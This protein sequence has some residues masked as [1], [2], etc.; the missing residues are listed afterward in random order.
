MSQDPTQPEVYAVQNRKNRPPDF[1]R[2]DHLVATHASVGHARLG[3]VD[4]ECR[5]LLKKSKWGTLDD[6]KG[7]IIYLDFAFNEPRDERLSSAVVQVTLDDENDYLK[8]QFPSDKTTSPLQIRIFGPH[9]IYGTPKHGNVGIKAGSIPSVGGIGYESIAEEYSWKLE[10]HLKPNSVKDTSGAYKVLQWHFTKNELQT[11][12]RHDSTIHTAFSFEHG[13]QPFYIRLDVRGKLER[14]SSNL[15]NKFSGIRKFPSTPSEAITL[16]NFKR[17]EIF[18]TPLDELEK[19]LELSMQLE[20]I[21]PPLAPLVVPE[22]EGQAAFE[23]QPQPMQQP[24]IIM[25]MEGLQSNPNSAGIQKNHP[26]PKP[27]ES[28]ETE[29]VV[30][31]RTPPQHEDIRTVSN[32]SYPSSVPFTNQL[33]SSGFSQSNPEPITEFTEYT[34]EDSAPAHQIQPTKQSEAFQ[35]FTTYSDSRFSHSHE[36]YIITLAEDLLEKIGSRDEQTLIRVSESLPDLLKSFALQMGYKAQTT[37]HQEI[38]V[39][40]HKNSKRIAESFRDQFTPE[41]SGPS[42]AERREQYNSRINRFLEDGADEAFASRAPS[43]IDLELRSYDEDPGQ[44]VDEDD[45]LV[46]GKEIEPPSVQEQEYRKLMTESP[47]YLWLIKT[48]QREAF[49]SR[50]DSNLMER[51]GATILK[52]LPSPHLSRK[53]SSKEHTAIFQLDWD[54]ISFLK[55][56]GYSQPPW[57]A[58]ERAITLT[59]SM[60][61]AQA[62]TTVDYISQVWSTSGKYAIALLTAAIRNTAG[63]SASLDLPNGGRLTTQIDGGKVVVTIIGVTPIII[64]VGQQLVWLSAALRSSSFETGVAICSPS[65]DVVE[66]DGRSNKG[67]TTADIICAVNFEITLA[68]TTSDEHQGHCW[69]KMFRNPVIVQGYPIPLKKHPGLGLE[70]PLA[71]MATLVGSNQ[72]SDFDGKTFIKGFSTML[73]AMKVAGDLIVWHYFYNSLQ[74]Y[75][76]YLYDGWDAAMGPSAQDIGLVELDTARHVVGWCSELKWNAGASDAAYDKID[77]SRLPRPHTGCF[78]EKVSISGGKFITVGATIAPGVKDIPI[79]VTLNSYVRKL[80]WLHSQYVIFWDEA[81]KRGW[82]VNGTSALLH[83]VRTSL[84]RSSTDDVFSSAL[85]FSPDKMVYPNDVNKPN[86]AAKVLLD[87]I[88][89][90]LEV[91][92]GKFVHSTEVTSQNVDGNV[93]EVK[94]SKKTMQATLFEDIV[95]DRFS[96]LERMIAYQQ[97]G[98]QNGINLKLRVRQHLEG[99]DFMD[100]ATGSI[101]HG[102]VATLDQVSYSWVEFAHSISAVFLFGKNF[103]EMIEPIRACPLWCTLPKGKYYLAASVIHLKMIQEREQVNTPSMASKFEWLTPS[104]PVAPCESCSHNGSLDGHNHNPVQILCPQASVS[105]TS[106]KEFSRPMELED[107][108]AVILGDRPKLGLPFKIQPRENL[109]ERHAGSTAVPKAAQD[110]SSSISSGSR[111]Q[112]SELSSFGRGSQGQGSE[113]EATSISAASSSLARSASVRSADKPSQNINEDKRKAS[114]AD[115]STDH[116]TPRQTAHPLSTQDPAPLRVPDRGMKTSLKRFM[117]TLR[118]VGGNYSIK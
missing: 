32:D 36:N 102:C 114:E 89:R 33:Y 26:S 23:D 103:G 8:Q 34:R 38:S 37:V 22:I 27:F 77:R 54:P 115:D 50:G 117:E 118:N 45:A 78:L 83:L 28:Y 57:E 55:E 5:L 82:L 107:S 6:R 25:S 3:K 109:E 98:G 81:D 4:V 31:S 51:I 20:N 76:S 87:D 80:E 79:H 101:L 13:G 96:F 88:N 47:A 75:Q 63:Y 46:L 106:Q 113:T 1:Q 43:E 72:V 99:W 10:G 60:D 56:Q 49:L 17:P 14:N 53:T 15:R 11:S 30:L 52:A 108:G 62:L 2:F 70:M 61:D 84:Q 94:V 97:K 16:I 19:Q 7:G 64:E 39:F 69:Q 86:T 58:F 90:Q 41:E 112:E 116:V 29:S 66:Q 71:M 92:A 21:R 24:P 44:G 93:S 18:T 59:G 65:M 73:V 104:S 105:R 9:Q 12:S 68:S 100:A 48:M 85:R 42:E 40:I 67:K 95:E 111:N 35:T 91:W 74:G 110:F